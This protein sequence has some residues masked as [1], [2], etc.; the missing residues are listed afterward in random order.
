M[1]KDYHTKGANY[2]EFKVTG[3]RQYKIGLKAAHVLGRPAYFSH[4]PNGQAHLVI[5]NFF[6][7]PSSVYSEEPT[8]LV[9][10]K[11]HSFHIYN[12]DGRFGGFAEL[13]CNGQTIGGSTGKSVSSDQLVFWI[14]IGEDEKVRRIA[15]HLL[16]VSLD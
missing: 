14:Y 13:E 11:G 12:D 7:N 2:N 3:K 9:G 15:H 10:T 8:N 4:L 6:N 1:P 16:G 5:C